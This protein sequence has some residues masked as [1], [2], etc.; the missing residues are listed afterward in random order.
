VADAAARPVRDEE[1]TKV[2]M[3]GARARVRELEQEVKT[4]RTELHRLAQLGVLSV[5]ELEQRRSGLTSEIVDHEATLEQSR[6][7]LAAELQQQ[8]SEA[9]VALHRDLSE[10]S[11]E[12]DTLKAE[13]EELR[14]QVVV[15]KEEV[16]LQEAGIYEYRHPLNDAVAYKG[17]L[18]RLRDR[19]KTMAVKDGGAVLAATDW[20][21]N[22]SAAQGRAMVR[23]YS[24]LILRAYNAEAD[25]LVRGLKPYKLHS[26][27]DRLT[28]VT[29]TVAKLGATMDIRIADTYHGL[30][31][32]ELELTADYLEKLA[33]E[34]ERE[35]E[36][37]ERLKEERLVQQEME[38]ERARLD[39]ERQHYGN[40]LDALVAKGDEEGAERLREQVAEID[41]RIE[42]VDYRAANIR[43]GY[44]YVI[45]NI[46][47]FGN[48]IVKVGLTRRLEPLERVRE[49][50]DA[51]VPFRFD[52][53]VVHFSEDAVGIEAELHRRL[54]DQ[55]VNLV[56]TR[57]EFF[58]VTPQEV[59]EH[60]AELAG[61]LLEYVEVPEAVEF[62]QSTTARRGAPEPA[63]RAQ[64]RE[65]EE[66]ALPRR[67]PGIG[68]P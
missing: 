1:V 30:R 11:Q 18:A 8:R 55:R 34:K 26:S 44:V 65:Q 20:S 42:D 4:L 16:V 43:A 23:N 27:I 2:P 37:R 29:T 45:S 24:K 19:I 5:A 38:R 3:F 28:K 56:N 63:S 64:E 59:K 6:R 61:E 40:A 12:R 57:R 60:L 47:S 36:E 53:H 52:V 51:S 50:G 9:E 31:V 17:E 67:P 68:P 13:L 32:Q 49:L 15:T 25:N 14:G 21:V 35:R 41:R 54:A 46:G 10:A 62:Q 66:P 7:D 58:Y 48:R 39:K 33:Q 22:G